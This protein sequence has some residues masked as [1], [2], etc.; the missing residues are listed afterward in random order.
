MTTRAKVELAAGILVLIAIVI[1]FSAWL[2][3][4]D[5]K[6]KAE[7]EVAAQKEAFDKAADQM[8]TLQAADKE[9]DAKTAETIAQLA[10]A[11]AKQVTPQQIASWIPQQIQNAP[12]PITVNIPPATAAN[13]KPDAVF[14]VP[15]ADLPTVRDAIEKCQVN[16]VQ[17]TGCQANLA[18]RDEQLKVAGEK[19]SA[20]ER[21]RDAYQTALKGGTFF[22]RVKRAGKWLLI[23]GAAGAVALCA[24]GHCR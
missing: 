20:V 14:S 3:E 7:S 8:K 12:Q 11:A 1:G 6:I 15:Q 5:A 13:P 23:G 21:E 18:S 2:G 10:Q 16:A 4:H 9:R 22:Q 19:L 24:S 17:L